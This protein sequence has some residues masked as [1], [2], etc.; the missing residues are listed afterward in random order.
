AQVLTATRDTAEYFETA[1]RLSG[2][3]QL[4]AKMAANWV[5]GSLMGMLKTNGRTIAESPVTAE[6]LGELV[7]LIGSGELSGKLAKE[8]FPKMFSTGAAA[9]AIIE[10]EGLKQISDT[11]ALE[12]TIADV[13][14]NNPKQVE[15]YRGGKTSVINFL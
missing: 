14:A 3:A 11:G 6:S 2:N 7:K 10:K 13:I 4:N 5:M 1:A 15:Q 9:A 8:I 12:Q